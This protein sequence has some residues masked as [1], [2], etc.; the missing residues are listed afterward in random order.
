MAEVEKE[1]KDMEL[2]RLEASTGQEDK[3]TEIAGPNPYEE[4]Y[5]LTNPVLLAD[6][7]FLH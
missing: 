1:V 2:K 7:G 3:C 4:N 5:N 6:E